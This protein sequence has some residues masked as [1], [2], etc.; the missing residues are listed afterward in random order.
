MQIA[1]KCVT[2]WWP[3][4]SQ[5]R[6]RKIR[7]KPPFNE[8]VKKKTQE[9]IPSQRLIISKPL[10]PSTSSLRISPPQ[11]RL[12][13]PPSAL[14]PLFSPSPLSNLC[15]VSSSC[16]CS[17]TF[18][19]HK[20]LVGLSNHSWSLLSATAEKWWKSVYRSKNDNKNQ[21]CLEW[22]SWDDKVQSVYLSIY[23]SIYSTTF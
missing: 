13:D 20:S 16:S 11:S 17:R 10:S 9:L 19:H 3:E 6:E 21:V 1:L 4:V 22:R 2:T 23:P 12:S 15:G 14:W 7:D 5:D 18:K 8:Q